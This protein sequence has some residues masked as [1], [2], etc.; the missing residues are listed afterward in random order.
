MNIFLSK[1]DGIHAL[2]RTPDAVR[3]LQTSLTLEGKAY[4]WW[5]SLKEKNI[6]P[7]S[8]AAFEAI[9]LK[10][11]LPTNECARLSHMSMQ[12]TCQYTVCEPQTAPSTQ[13]A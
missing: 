6:I 2:R 5:M 11:F 3:A 10:E 13:Q 7:Q 9:F 12:G 8:W 4:K 1:W